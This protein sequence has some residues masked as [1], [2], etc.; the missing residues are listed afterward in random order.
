M[1]FTKND[2]SFRS[3]ITNKMVADAVSAALR[4]EHYNVTASIKQ[5]ERVTGIS[6]STACKW[7]NGVYAPKSNH[8]LML[9]AYYPM[10]L[11]AMFELMEC[12]PVWQ[13]AVRLR[14]VDT[15]RSQLKKK[16]E[17][18]KKSSTT[19][20][21]FVTIRVRLDA[22]MAGQ[23]NHRQLWFLGQLQQGYRTYRSDLMEIWHVHARTAK[24]DITGLRKVGLIRSV[25]HGRESR[26]ELL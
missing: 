16:W 21:K 23:L 14:M 3:E 13:E 18:W 8:L 5:I 26:Y 25:K 2:Q 24:R 22:H 6:G 12:N 17:K 20:D 10:V 19:G 1:S 7:Y 15:M 9:A 11:Q 4:Q